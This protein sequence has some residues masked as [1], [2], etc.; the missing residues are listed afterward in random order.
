MAEETN[1]HPATAGENLQPRYPPGYWDE[2][3]DYLRDCYLLQHNNDYLEFL[4][5][6]VWQLDK[7]C[8]VVEFG[9]G[10]GKMGL[11]LML[12]LSVGSSYTGIDQ[13]TQ[14][15]ERGRQVW[16]GTS[17]SAVF[18]KGSI[19][20]TTFADDSFDVAFTHT[21]LMHVPHPEKALLEMIRVTHPGGLV[22]A[23]EANRNAHT[24]LLHIEETNHQEATPLDLFQTLN[25]SIRQHTGVDHNIGVKMPVLMHRAGLID[26]QARQSDAVRCLFPP[27]DTPEKQELFKAICDEGYGQPQPDAEQRAR[28]KQNLIDQGIS[29]QA[30]EAEIERE[31]AEDFLQQGSSYHTVYTTSLTWSFGKV[32]K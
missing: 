3:G 26:V 28:W 2:G 18:H 17:W 21:V 10:F 23:C 27:L 15:I 1:L 9:C 8:R 11:Q 5:Q 6:R 30:A 16:A 14:L 20:E 4:V 31:L 13:S 24:A 12:L 22:I 25:R 19:Y 32:K 7:P 29:E